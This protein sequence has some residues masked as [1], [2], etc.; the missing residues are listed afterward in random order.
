M[1][2]LLCA[3]LC[4]T[5]LLSVFLIPAGAL[6]DLNAETVTLADKASLKVPCGQSGSVWNSYINV[7]DTNNP[8]S[9]Q[10]TVTIW[11]RP[12][13]GW[14]QYY[15]SLSFVLADGNFSGKGE[16]TAGSRVAGLQNKTQ[17]NG[18]TFNVL[19]GDGTSGSTSLNLVLGAWNRLDMVVDFD[20]GELTGYLNYQSLGT[21]TIA[22]GRT[23]YRTII[24]PIASGTNNQKYAYLDN[25]M[26]RTGCHAPVKGDVASNVSVETLVANKTNILYFDSFDN[27]EIIAVGSLAYQQAKGKIASGYQSYITKDETIG[28]SA[29]DAGAQFRGVQHSAVDG[30]Y[31]IRLLGT[32]DSLNY[33]KVGFK[34]AVKGYEAVNDYA[35]NVYDSVI[36]ANGIAETETYSALGTYG[37]GYI[38]ASTINGLSATGTYEITVTPITVDAEGVPTE[39]TPYV[40]NCVSGVVTATAA[41]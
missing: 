28:L 17:G 4:L 11:M 37:A 9:G 15:N 24:M 35:V 2:K 27:S 36:G 22:E 40:V 26:V 5:M 38:Y 20:K 8:I 33:K 23:S 32:I 31:N 13:D 25:L 10:S 19:N 1:K 12:Q 34:I 30:T 39:H 21:A 7:A 29:Q 16:T 18:R 6:T 3:I 14:E 41:N